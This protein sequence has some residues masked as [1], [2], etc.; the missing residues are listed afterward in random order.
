MKDK[1]EKLVRFNR[2]MGILHLIQAIMMLFLATTVIGKIAEFSPTITKLYLEFN[3]TTQSLEQASKPLFELPFGVLVSLFLFISAFAHFFIVFKKKKY[4]EDLKE[5]INKFRWIEYALSSS[6]MIVLIATLFGVYDIS[7]LILIF[8]VNASMNLFGL[9]MEQLNVGQDKKKV[10]WEP[11]IWGSIAGLAPW[12]VIL[13]YM[14]GNGNLDMVPWFVW[15]IVATY[16]VTFNTFPINMILQYKK[17]GKW[18]DYLYG[19]RVYI[20]LS[21]VAKTALAWLVLFGAMQP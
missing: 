18:K 1:Y 10:N 13:I 6:I 3:T 5:G 11:F 4:V 9:V 21:L 15:A 14:F 17:T 16:F 20:I 7:S 19:E 8:V 2:N 12:I